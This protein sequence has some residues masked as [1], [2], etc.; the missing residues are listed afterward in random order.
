M[1]RHPGD[2]ALRDQFLLDPS[3][4]FFNHGCFGACPRP[5]MEAYQAWQLEL[6]RQ[7][8]EFLGRRMTERMR[9]ARGVLAAELG[10]NIDDIVYVSNATTGLN[11]VARALRL[12]PGD[13]VLATDHEY[14]ALDRTWRFVCRKA[15]ATYVRQPVRL[16][17]TSQREVAEQIWAGVSDRTR[18]LFLSHISSLTALRFPVDVLI[19][20]ARDAGILTVIDGAHVP[21]H[22]DLDLNALGADI[23]VGNCHKWMMSPKGAAFLHARTDAQSLIEPLVVS[24]GWE[25][26][27]PGPSQFVDHHEWQGTRDIAPFLAVP[28]A[29]KFAED[30]EWEPIRHQCHTLLSG[31]RK[32]MV[33]LTGEPLLYPD[34]E[35]WFRQMHTFRLP[36]GVDGDALARR[37]YDEDRIELPAVWWADRWHIRVSMQGYNGEEDLDRLAASLRRCLPR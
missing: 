14:G 25:S 12:N 5:V 31:F 6:E 8:V 15:G 33:E 20:R 35:A 17:A 3:V 9:W 32:R 4:S 16:P 34:S 11:A 36:A 23:Y 7:P 27:Q 10:A 28:A 24:W 30:H 2:E 37:I 19:S 29:I 21:G 18:V 26:E 13:E 22:I 1:T